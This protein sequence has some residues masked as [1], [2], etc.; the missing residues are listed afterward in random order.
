MSG[1][2]WAG[3]ICVAVVLPL[4]TAMILHDLSIGEF[5]ARPLVLVALGVVA[6]VVYRRRQRPNDSGDA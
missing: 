6:G 4:A 2:A 5:P 3:A 1:R